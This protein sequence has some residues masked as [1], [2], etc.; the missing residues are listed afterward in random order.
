MYPGGGRR[1]REREREGGTTRERGVC[2]VCSRLSPEVCLDVICQT[3]VA[4]VPYNSLA[5]TEGKAVDGWP[6]TE[7]EGRPG[8]TRLGRQLPGTDNILGE[9]ADCG[10]SR[11]PRVTKLII[12]LSESTEWQTGVRMGDLDM[13]LIRCYISMVFLPI[14][15]SQNAGIIIDLF[16]YWHL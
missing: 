9:M 14:T 10:D 16:I 2:V 13:T 11:K 4:A 15:D 3:C 7:S 12:H 6:G 5:R 8:Q 1:E